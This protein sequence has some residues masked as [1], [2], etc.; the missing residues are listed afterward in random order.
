MNRLVTR[1]IWENKEHIVWIL[2]AWGEK[3][4]AFRECDVWCFSWQWSPGALYSL[5][6]Y[7]FFSTFF[8]GLWSTDYVNK[9]QFFPIYLCY[10]FC[11]NID[12]PWKIKVSLFNWKCLFYWAQSSGG[13]YTK[14]SGCFGCLRMRSDFFMVTKSETWWVVATFS[15]WIWMV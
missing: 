8:I 13:V 11:V 12:A 5:T 14:V 4:M 6:L 9:I 7:F 10:S 1:I 15:M 2:A 3:Q